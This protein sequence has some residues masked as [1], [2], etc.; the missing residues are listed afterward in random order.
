MKRICVTKFKCFLSFENLN[1]P[2]LIC[3][4][5][6]EL[7]LLKVL[8]GDLLQMQKLYVEAQWC[9][10]HISG[11]RGPPT[12][13]YLLCGQKARKLGNVSSTLFTY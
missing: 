7:C 11:R 2:A 6:V 5:Q 4:M 9:Q 8:V 1:L 13:Y 10:V 12:S 3:N